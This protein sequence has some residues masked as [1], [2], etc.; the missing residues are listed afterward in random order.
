MKKVTLSILIAYSIL[1]GLGQAHARGKPGGGGIDPQVFAATV[2]GP[3]N[4]LVQYDG[5]GNPGNHLGPLYTRPD[6][7]S[8]DPKN[9]NFVGNGSNEVKVLLDKSFFLESNGGPFS[10]AQV[11]QCFPDEV[12]DASLH[13]TNY[14]NGKNADYVA[15]FWFWGKSLNGE[16]VQYMLEFQTSTGDGWYGGDFPPKLHEA[17]YRSADIWAI[18]AGNSVDGCVSAGNILD[19]DDVFAAELEQVDVCQYPYDLLECPQ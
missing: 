13:L 8:A 15:I 3:L 4:S 9:V 2:T 1:L 10:Q 18:S 17:I 11:D 16:V 6:Q 14:V 19:E 12:Y 5:S 7:N